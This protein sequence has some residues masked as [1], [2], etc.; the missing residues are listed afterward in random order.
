MSPTQAAAPRQ[1]SGP[2]P[3]EGS[4]DEWYT[5]RED[6]RPLHEEFGFTLDACATAESAT[7]PR[8]YSKEQ[9]GLVQFWAGERVWCNPPYNPKDLPLWVAKCAHEASAGAQLVVALVPSRT[10]VRWWHE[11]IEPGRIAG[12]LEVRFLKGRLR[13]GWPGMPEGHPRCSGRFPNA[14]IIWRAPRAAPEGEP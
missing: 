2:K 10:D 7:V 3:P 9:N 6:F 8:F 4:T 11:H 1:R 12:T 5:R 13:F 14:L